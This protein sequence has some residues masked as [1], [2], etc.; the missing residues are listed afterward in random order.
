MTANK[1]ARMNPPPQF[2]VELLAELRRLQPN[3]TVEILIPAL[4]G[5]VGLVGG[6]LLSIWKDA[7]DRKRGGLEAAAQRA[8]LRRAEAVES[9]IE[10]GR[11]WVRHFDIA[12]REWESSDKVV[13][14]RFLSIGIQS[15]A[16]IQAPAL[17]LIERIKTA[18]RS[19]RQTDSEGNIVTNQSGLPELSPRYN[20]DLVDAFQRPLNV[21]QGQAQLWV[22]GALAAPF[23]IEAID[24]AARDIDQLANEVSVPHGHV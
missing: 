19:Y 3:T 14:D 17:D 10:T 24:V 9:L 11:Q 16:L 1:L 18:V 21:L 6:F 8:S 7:R 23:L 22:E 20:A 5:A 12:G 13:S 2:W 4:T 15:D